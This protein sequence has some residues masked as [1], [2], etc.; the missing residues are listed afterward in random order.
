MRALRV[1]DFLIAAIRRSEQW[2]VWLEFH[3]TDDEEADWSWLSWSLP[4]LQELGE[5]RATLC[6][7][8]RRHGVGLVACEGEEEARSCFERIQGYRVGVTVYPR[9]GADWS[10]AARRQPRKKRKRPA[11]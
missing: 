7:D 10:M 6:T 3:P 4:W 2:V 1:E 5:G 9:R 8:L 11:P